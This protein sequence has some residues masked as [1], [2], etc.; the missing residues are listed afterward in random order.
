VVQ[1]HWGTI[2]ASFRKPL[3]STKD[4]HKQ[5]CVSLSLLFLILFQVDIDKERERERERVSLRAASYLNNWQAHDKCWNIF[6]YFTSC[7]I[8]TC[9]YTFMEYS[10]IIRYTYTMSSDQIRTISTS[11][12][13]N[14]NH[15]CML[16]TFIFF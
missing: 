10:M 15:F 11:I 12:F 7:F 2:L 4:F 9:L 6:H 16:T 5:K 3:F 1:W 8:E 14:I 13:S